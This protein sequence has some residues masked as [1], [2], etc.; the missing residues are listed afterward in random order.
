M[1]DKEISHYNVIVYDYVS[2]I[3][4]YRLFKTIKCDTEESAVEIARDYI[5][6][7]NIKFKVNI[8]Q[9][10]NVIGWES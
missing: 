3:G 5:E 4:G 6:D 10:C 1:F 8:E 7:K 9:V 2:S